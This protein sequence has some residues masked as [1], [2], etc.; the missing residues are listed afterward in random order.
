MHCIENSFRSNAI[1]LSTVSIC[2]ALTLC[3]CGN[4]KADA[5]TLRSGIQ[6]KEAELAIAQKT[7]DDTKASRRPDWRLSSEATALQ[8]KIDKLTA[9]KDAL[10]SQ[11]NPI[12]QREQEASQERQAAAVQKV[13]SDNQ[14]PSPDADLQAAL[15][16]DRYN[17]LITLL[18]STWIG[19]NSNGKSLVFKCEGATDIFDRM[20]SQYLA[21]KDDAGNVILEGFDLTVPPAST[22][23]TFGIEGDKGSGAFL[24]TNGM[25]ISFPPSSKLGRVKFSVKAD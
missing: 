20:I 14:L 16:D 5:E 8:A 15:K 9:E 13:I 7:F 2:L 10:E 18:R 3:G 1:I 23:F 17:T 11:L 4:K 24:S 22:V 21:V 12:I 25:M 6:E 19:T